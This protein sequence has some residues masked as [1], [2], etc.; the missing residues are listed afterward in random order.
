MQKIVAITS[1][2]TGIAHTLMA[3]EAL[4]K[5]GTMLGY[6]IKVETQGAEGTRNEL[7]EED[8]EAADVVILATD[9]TVDT[10]RFE[11]KPVYE[12]STSEAIR[13]TTRVLDEAVK[14]APLPPVSTVATVPALPDTTPPAPVISQPPQVPSADAGSSPK[15]VIGITSCPTGIAHTFMA[16]KALE[17]AAKALGH[18]VK[19]ETQ[20][21]VGAQNVLS[22]EDVA[23]ADAVVIAA[24]TK[25]DISRFGGKRLYQTSTNDA[26][27]NGQAVVNKALALPLAAPGS[28]DLAKQVESLKSERS[29]QRTGPYKHLMTGISYMLP[30][31]VAGGLLTAISFAFGGIH[32]S[33]AKDTF[34]ASLAEIG[35][36]A[37]SIY[38][39]VLAAFIAFS[40]ADRP[41]IAPGF[42]TGMVAKDIGAGF[43]GGIAA[44]F[45][46]GYLVK[47][48]NSKLKLGPLDSLKP[49]LIL[50]FICSLVSGLLMFWVIGKPVAFILTNLTD[51]L[52][53]MQTG[54]AIILGIILGAMM[55]FDMGGPVNK[56]AY[57]FGV[58]LLA[59][60]LYTPMAAVMAAGMTPPLGLALAS[61][62]FKNKFD[63]QDQQAASSAFVLGLS[64]ITEGAIPYASKDLFRVIPSI[65][66]GSA[67]AGAISMSVGSQLVVSHGGLFVLF[68]PS[69]ITNLP[70]YIVAILAGT[71]VT[72]G[73]LF[74][75][76]RPVEEAPRK[77]E[78]PVIQNTSAQVT[79]V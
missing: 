73:A 6:D 27:N 63:K 29:K 25:V 39:G 12:T 77:V 53:T 35:S 22:E 20:G 43:L 23:E 28:V 2:P 74:V 47:Y 46:A 61:T 57:T 24:D 36:A 31:V 79:K 44:G 3:A 41:G 15:Y 71:L 16:A 67:T 49:V 58:G 69:A 30:F 4:R 55:A 59:S 14:L 7:T 21:S 5:T 1:C 68:I 51:W 17:N 60:Q 26:I 11:G 33:D 52:K 40:I 54:N 18:K 42:I 72:T 38:I 50:P 70:M 9:I 10:E 19:I 13:N 78:K 66:L 45:L 8:I 62:L 32:A 64:F 34:G 48:L 75:L 65:M 56:A 37:F 76:K